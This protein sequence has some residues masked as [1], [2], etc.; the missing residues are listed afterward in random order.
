MSNDSGRESIDS[1]LTVADVEI[2]WVDRSHF[3]IPRRW[4]EKDSRVV[5][6]PGPADAWC[7][8]DIERIM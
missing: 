2:C 6:Y 5:L 8:G 3:E 7:E 1:V 4:M